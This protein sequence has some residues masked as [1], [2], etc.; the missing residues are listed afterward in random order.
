MSKTV[1][2]TG[3]EDYN[4]PLFERRLDSPDTS[5]TRYGVLEACVIEESP[6]V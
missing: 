5:P 3:L 1:A 2:F 4:E 6:D